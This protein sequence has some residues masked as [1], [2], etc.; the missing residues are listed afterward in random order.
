MP[1]VHY[2]YGGSTCSRTINCPAWRRVSQNMPRNVGSNEHADRGSLLHD[3]MEVL[4]TEEDIEFNDLLG[5]TYNDQ[6]LTS[7]LLSEVVIPTWMSYEDFADK[8]QFDTEMFEIEVKEEEDIGGTI[9]ILAVNHDTI[10]VIDWKFG[11]N[12]V[13]PIENAQGLFYAMCAQTDEKT[14]KL[15]TEKRKKLV[16]G[17]IQPQNESEGKELIQVWETEVERLNTF[18]TEFYEAIDE[19]ADTEEPNAGDWCTYCP[20]LS[21][22]PVKTGEARKALMIDPASAEAAELSI[23]MGMVNNIEEWAKEVRRRAH[24][25]AEL[26]MKIQGYKLVQKRS[27][28]QWK[29][30]DDLEKCVKVVKGLDIEDALVSNFKSPAQLEA[31]CKAKDIDFDKFKG[32]ISNDSSGTTLVLNNDNRQEIIGLTGLSEAIKSI[33]N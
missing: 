2:E 4:G 22:C 28:R 14:M 13:S 25:Q 16:I 9:D 27:F 30:L 31:T 29:S 20:G 32:V 17:I 3:C 11:Y 33:T 26:G 10:F 21:I 1:T 8:Y 5:T 23:A 12:L 24:E 18:A 6:I 7:E 15:F 19:R